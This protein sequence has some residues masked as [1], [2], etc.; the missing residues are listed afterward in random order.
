[1]RYAESAAIV[2]A[3]NT[4]DSPHRVTIAGE[5]GLRTPV[6]LKGQNQTLKFEQPGS[7]DYICGLHPGM[8]GRIDVK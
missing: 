3:A 4:D 1:M 6:I 7:Y 2:G 5:G 8:K